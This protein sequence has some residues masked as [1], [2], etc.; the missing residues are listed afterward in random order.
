L[1]FEGR[2]RDIRNHF[3]QMG[4][5]PSDPLRVFVGQAP[6]DVAYRV[7]QQAIAE[8][9][10][11]I[12]VDT[13]Q[14]FLRAQSTDDYAEMTTLFDAVIGIAGESGATMLLLH[15]GSK[16]DR[17]GIDAVLGSTAITG[18]A[19]TIILLTRSERFRT[20]SIVQRAG[21]DLP[22]TLIL[23]DETTGRVR[24]GGTRADAE[25]QA[26]ADAILAVLSA[27]DA[28]LT[29]P[30]IAERVDA[31]T[32]LQRRALRD[33]VAR[34]QASRTGRGGKGD[35][36]RYSVSHSRSLVPSIDGEQENNHSVSN[37]SP[38]RSEPDSCSLVPA[39]ELATQEASEPDPSVCPVCG[40]DACEDDE[41]T[42]VR[43]Q[44]RVATDVDDV[45]GSLAW[46]VVR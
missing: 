36:Y 37:G 28:P 34:E 13:M 27:A 17:A 12:V 30:E 22:E 8:R 18:S 4:A 46:S 33:L 39:R 23:L 29:E 31:R 20:I 26:V 45:F 1:G 38:R 2:R 7:R 5:R 32:A 19:D 24:L 10:V 43:R 16:A 3:R 35:P 42:C 25:Q 21:D 41:A 9:P 6:A 14:R 11:L 15:H 44:S 40:R